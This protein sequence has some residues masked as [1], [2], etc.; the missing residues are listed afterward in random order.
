MLSLPTRGVWIEITTYALI[1]P[2]GTSSL[3]TRGVWIE[4]DCCCDI[5][6]SAMSLPTRG[7]WIEIIERK[8]YE[9]SAKVTPHTGSV[10]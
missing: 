3:P 1:Q 8:I 6:K 2:Y 9:D 4:I 7:V 10:D 5:E